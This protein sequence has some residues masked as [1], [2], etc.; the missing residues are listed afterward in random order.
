MFDF[1]SISTGKSVFIIAEAGVNHNG[2]L[3][4]AMKLVDEAKA[5]GADAVKFQTFKADKLV[6]RSAQKAEYQKKS[7]GSDENQFNMLKR[8]ELNSEDHKTLFEYC[9]EKGILFISTPFDMQSVD[10]L[11]KLGVEAYKIGSGD[12]TNMPMLKKIAALKKPVIFSTGMASV[13]EIKEA[14]DWFRESGNPELIL[15]HC[16]TSYPAPYSDVNLRAMETLKKL[17][18]LPVGYSDHTAGIEVPIAAVAL[19]ACVIEKHFTLDRNMEGPDH[20]AS[21]EPE[22]LKQMVASIRNI[23]KALGSPEKTITKTESSISKVARKSIVSSKRITAGKRLTIDDIEVKR[24]GD[25]IAPK[26]FFDLLEGYT[27][28]VEIEADTPI[29]WYMLKKEV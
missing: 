24:P 9:K 8:L 6:T 18:D 16:T 23:E 17:T 5:A 15:L 21:I 12:L 2:S 3:E 29:Q 20:K 7:T 14:L 13:T 4:M 10:L 19:G 27:A 22:E 26:Q 25:G 28:L 11:E 1:K